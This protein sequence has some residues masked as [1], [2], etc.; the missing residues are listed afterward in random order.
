LPVKLIEFWI[1]YYLTPIIISGKLVNPVHEKNKKIGKIIDNVPFNWHKKILKF[2]EKQSWG[3]DH[4][5]R[6]PPIK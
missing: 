2:K 5:R 1:T 6:Y 4:P 3:I